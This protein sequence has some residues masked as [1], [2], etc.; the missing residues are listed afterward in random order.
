MLPT[1]TFPPAAFSIFPLNAIGRYGTMNIAEH[2]T[3][4][5]EIGWV[6]QG[7]VTLAMG[8][9]ALPVPE[10]AL[11]CR[12]QGRKYQLQLTDHAE[13]YMIRCNPSLLHGDEQYFDYKFQ[14]GLQ[15]LLEGVTIVEPEEDAL[16]ALN[17]LFGLLMQEYTSQRTLR[18]E[19]ISQF[20]NI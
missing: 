12:K 18:R 1:E 3:G 11:F 7:R 14:A 4:S 9:G 15:Q 17:T 20:L 10:G 13:G 6:K 16:S 2:F 5:I 19:M 8:N